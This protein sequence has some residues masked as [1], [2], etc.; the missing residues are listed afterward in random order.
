MAVTS[1]P[2]SSLSPSETVVKLPHPYQTEYA[3]RKSSSSS[4][5]APL[6]QVALKSSTTTSQLPLELHSSALYFSEPIGLK[7]SELPADSNN[8]SWAR[9]R[10]APCVTT[11][12]E[13]R[14]PPSLA[15]AWL[16]LYVLFT[17]NPGNETLRLELKGTGASVLAQQ[18]QD[19]LLAIAHPLPAREKRVAQP[20]ST[21]STVLALRS[22]FW[23]G[24][25]SPFGPR[26]VWCP[27]ES[28]SSLSATNPLA[29]YP[30]TP[31][32]H[33]MTIA[34]AGDPQDPERY[35]QIWHPIRPA[36]PAPGA[37]VY[38]R[39]IP[40]LK[41]TFSMVS[42][43]WEDPEHLRLFHEWQNDPRVSQGWNETGTLDQHRAYLRN[44]HEDPH[45]VAL[46]AKWDD[47]FFAYFEVYWAKEDRLGGYY[48]A[49]DFDRGRHSLV[50]DVRFRGPHRVSAWWSSLMHYLYLD[51][52]RTVWVVGEPKETNSTVVMYDLIHGFGLDKFVDLPHKRSAFVRCSRERF[53]Q[54]CPLAESEKAVGGMRI[55]LVPKLPQAPS[56]TIRTLPFTDNPSSVPSVGPATPRTHHPQSST[57][58]GKRGGRPA[59]DAP[60]R[61]EVEYELSDLKSN[62]E[63]D[64][65]D[66][67]EERRRIKRSEKRQWLEQ[68][69]EMKFSHS[70]QFNAVP[71]WSSHYIA[72][73]N[74][75]KLIYQLEKT[76][77]QTRAGDAES[78]PL[79]TS[80]EPEEVF[81]R[82]L[83]VELEK[84]CSFYVAKEG[85]LFDEVRQLQKDI[86]ESAKT[87][88]LPT[89]HT[90]SDSSRLQLTNSNGPRSS[91]EGDN[92]DEEESGS[93]DDEMTGL[94]KR[95]SSLGRRRS[96][97]SAQLHQSIDMTASSDFG[98][99]ARRQSTAADDY[100]EQSLMFGPGLY[101]SSIMLK[102]RIIS[103][104]V[105]LC[106]L[107]S[108][109]QLNRTGFRKVLKKFDK[110]LGKELKSAYMEQH[111]DTAYPFK[112]ETKALLENHIA[113]MEAS[114]AEVVTGGD[115]ELAK[116]DLRSHLREHVVWERNTVWRDLIGLERRAEAARLGQALLGQG[117][118]AMHTRLQGDDEQ[119]VSL[120]QIPTP[121][122]RLRLPAWLVSSSILALVL[123]IVAFFLLLFIP[124]MEKEDEQNCL[125]L[126]VFVSMLWATETIPLFVTALLIPFLA[127]VLNVVR[128]E[129]PGSQHRRLNS[130]DASKEIFAAMW[131]PVIMLLLGGFTLAA[132]LSKCKIDKRLATLV[133]SKAGTR[134]KTVLLANMFVA[135]VASML[136]SNVAAP[137]LCYSIIEP[138][139]RTL[140]SD[141]NM[142]KAVI[143]GIALA[144]NIGGMLSPIASPQNVVAMDIM[145]PSPGWI[146]WLFIAIPVGTISLLLIW[147]LLL[148]TF[149]PGNTTISPIRPVK[150]K[151]TGVQWF[152]SVVTIATIALWCASHQL[153]DVFGDMGVI[154]IVPM[155]LFFGIGILT[156]EDFN[157]FPWT[158][159][160][161]A[162][163]GLSLGKAV[164]SSG[165]LHTVANLVSEHVAGMGLYGVLVVFS[166]LILVIATFISHTVAALIFLPLVFNVGEAMDQPHPN[167]LVMGGVLM[168]SAAMG[169]P[170]SGFPNMTAIMK[171]DAA[172]QRYLQVKHFISRGVPSSMITLVVAVTLGYGIMEV[173][174]L[175]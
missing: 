123:C 126:L 92:L 159:I 76:V 11:A 175:D 65:A 114:Y 86:G 101:S 163:G 95:K 21:T 113:K 3:I 138:M 49:G 98:R 142:S 31:V 33:T 91:F 156:K 115:E 105:Q 70:I 149:N 67:R 109:V 14:E 120:K 103:L 75:K 5:D 18:L 36:K 122:G 68:Q 166:A 13:G 28:P 66:S 20:D 22:T 79:I 69:D 153:E 117:N 51:D 84:I 80:E 32:H 27:Q 157:N 174:G 102:K 26:S 148:L 154:A 30:L 89:L 58:P 8:S 167:L 7:S 96:V 83:G 136:I 164:R 23:Q 151:F 99:S 129:G 54:L 155:V 97:P 144:S 137:V 46:L 10:R 42:L 17:L 55:G 34:S 78:R 50:G 173:A 56:F 111:V 9:A 63:H 71:D 152:V 52:P 90:A 168:C 81:S 1:T 59:Q 150:E 133:L 74:L 140:P 162:A 87:D 41:E 172:G 85:E 62:R 145:K 147:L 60:D 135:A 170:T 139:L 119:L 130:K 131:T 12:W 93:D 161:L 64:E 132:A 141:S 25:G 72:Y 40:H 158:I 15:Q 57:G 44:I 47:T 4:S 39:W 100:G 146:Q 121:L 16:L 107:K 106:E 24:A 61:A 128:E 104:Y 77:H 124:F 134:P 35:Q 116:K 160:I 43:D 29:S 19:V 82:A 94:T 169:L 88:G 6:Y 37:V 127:T 118:T 38:S 112:E 143:I 110:T 108:Y 125:A 2:L 45:Q 48:D 73:S 171:E 165:L 53:F